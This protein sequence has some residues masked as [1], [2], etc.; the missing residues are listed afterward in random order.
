MVKGQMLVSAY[1]YVEISNN[2]PCTFW[3]VLFIPNESMKKYVINSKKWF[4][5]TSTYM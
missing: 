2:L 3:I 1:N 4:A 5:F